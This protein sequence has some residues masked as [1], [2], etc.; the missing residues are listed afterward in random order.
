[1]RQFSLLLVGIFAF[2]MGC[3][4]IE[5]GNRLKDTS[6]QIDGSQ[7][8]LLE[9]FTGVKCNNCPEANAE[10]KRLKDIYGDKLILLGIHAGNFAQTDKDHPKAFRT[11]AGTKFYNDFT[12]VG[13]PVAFLNRVDYD[14]VNNVAFDMSKGKDSWATE[15]DTLV[16]REAKAA[17]SVRQKS[18]D[19]TTRRLTVEGD[20]E[21]LDELPS[22]NVFLSLFLAENDIISPQTMPDKSI[23]TDYEHDHVFRGTFTGPYGQ[24][25]NLSS[26][27]A[28][29][30]KSLVLDEEIVKANCEVI[31]F[32]YNRDDFEIIQVAKVD[33]D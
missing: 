5:E 16:Q 19:A 28:S 8:V 4:T 23:Q 12:V 1:M 30:E 31:A 29:Y 27:S 15:V 33:L 18:Y 17:I 32:I 6:V 25:I 11:E 7:R 21:V 3:N 20:V 9:E 13:V 24:P 22:N 26:G 14:T 10:A 2:A